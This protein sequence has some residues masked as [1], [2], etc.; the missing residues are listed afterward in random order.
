MTDEELVTVMSRLKLTLTFFKNKYGPTAVILE[1]QNGACYYLQKGTLIRKATTMVKGGKTNLSYILGNSSS[2]E[3]SRNYPNYWRITECGVL[4]SKRTP[5]VMR[6]TKSKT[7]YWTVATR[8]GG[9]NG[10]SICVKVHREVAFAFVDNPF[11]YEM[12]NHVDGDKL[13]NHRSNLEWCNAKHNM[14]HAR[15]NGLLGL[16]LNESS[17]LSLEIVNMVREWAFYKSHYRIRDDLLSL[18]NITI[19]RPNVSDIVTRKSYKFYF[20]AETV[21]IFHYPNMREFEKYKKSRSMADSWIKELVESNDGSVKV[22]VDLSEKLFN[23]LQDV[24]VPVNSELM[25]GFKRFIVNE[26]S[27]FEKL[28]R[29]VNNCTVVSVKKILNDA[30]LVTAKIGS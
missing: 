10:K 23:D 9:R 14:T 29:G 15:D 16:T 6:Q 19:S 28:V 18:F 8:L 22:V 27:D 12:V 5:I 30:I 17:V 1:T 2:V 21:K 25:K 13:N 3:D 24:D 7:G 20:D 4:L 26:L 11:E